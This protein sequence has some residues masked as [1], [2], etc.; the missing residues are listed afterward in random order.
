MAN[1]LNAEKITDILLEKGIISE[2]EKQFILK[3]FS[4]REKKLFQERLI[5]SRTSKAKKVVSEE[6]SAPEVIASLKMKV[7][8]NKKEL[9]E[10][11]I[12]KAFAD[13]AGLE[14]KKIDPLKLDV[15]KITKIF[16]RAFARQHIALPLEVTDDAVTVALTDPYNMNTMDGIKKVTNL[17][18]N[19]V[20][21]TKTDILKT[22]TEFYGFRSSVVAAEKELH[23]SY[24]IQNLEQYIK[25]Q[26]V[27][28]IES[29]D[30]HI[31]N[32]VDY[33][34]HYAFEQRASDIH[35]EPK[36][37]D[38]ITRI[39]I[40]G[41]LHNLHRVPKLVHNAIVSRIKTLSRMDIA[42]KRR[43]Q[44]GRIKTDHQGREVELRVSTLPVAFG[45]KVVMRIF[46]PE[47]LMQ[48]LK[49]LGFTDKE[50]NLFN[51]FITQP[52]GII[53]VTGP[54]GSGKTTT[55]YSALKKISTEEKN[56][57]TIEDPIEMICE[58]FN[59]IA[60]MPSVDLTFA[61]SLRTI[62]R[63]DPDIIMVGEIRDLETAQNAIQS[64][65]TG[66][67]VLSTLHTNDAA[68]SITRLIDMGVEPF[69]ISS[70]VLGIMAQRLVR[71]VCPHCVF[72][73]KMTEDEISSL[74][75]KFKS[76][77]D[78]VVKEGAGCIQCRKTGYKGRTGIYEI[79]RIDSNI[80]LLINDKSDAS[81][82]KKEARKKG[83]S[84]LRES[85]I[86]KLLKG[87][88]T[89]AEIIRVTSTI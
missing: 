51:S 70:T 84:T 15:H 23:T 3:N 36:K 42:E 14:Y 40:D 87:E 28:E 72:E 73:R 10:E 45:E 19:L 12:M 39:R 89:V 86:K 62:L 6:V 56:I 24:D 76:K 71:K 88:T 77:K 7:G 13:Y 35:I 20:I 66:H 22:I 57:T 1:I 27:S 37:Q 80:K 44:D 34:L 5:A 4:V 81:I 78:I 85:A 58:E 82:I 32:A 46:D 83:M 26:D 9:T 69:L 55:L 47:I 30:Q 74:N 43:P 53:L 79:L 29:T 75:V 16:T 61:K 25:I 18:I 2:E 50:Y 31:I 64:A 11:V 38:S 65:L 8:Q 48:D 59:Q 63:Q 52:H 54:T 67:L 33:L 21:S 60:V 17:K 41:V 49:E 68:S